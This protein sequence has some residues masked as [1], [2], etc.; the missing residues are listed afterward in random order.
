METI[1]NHHKEP[2]IYKLETIR[3]NPFTKS[4]KLFNIMFFEGKTFKLDGLKTGQSLSI[5][6]EFEN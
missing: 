5:K 3:N 6:E 4:I 2:L 1:F